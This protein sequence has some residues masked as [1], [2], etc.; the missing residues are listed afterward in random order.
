MPKTK[1]KKSKSSKKGK[2]KKMQVKIKKPQIKFKK[3][4]LEGIKESNITK[5][6]LLVL[7]ILVFFVIID[8]GVQYLNNDYSAAVVNGKRITEREYFYRLDQAYGS[9]IVSQLI[10][11]ALVRQE[12]EK[13]GVIATEEEIDEQLADIT[14]QVGGEEQLNLSLETYNLTMEDLRRQIE[15]D[16][17][18]RKMIEPTL[19][20]TDEDVKAFFEEFSEAIFPEESAELEEGEL[21]DYETYK[22]ETLDVFIQQE[23]STAQGPWLAEL[24]ANAKIQNNVLEGPGYKFLGATR[25]IV[26]NIWDDINSNEAESTETDDGENADTE[27]AE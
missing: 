4:T 23:I 26:Q 11:E 5:Y 24:K 13:E 10:D 9:A 17:L 14:E 16:V 22:D 1:N 27:S 7:L 20:Y 19:D 3:P 21:L 8:F 25:N 18:T 6:S 2:S 12:A 15:L